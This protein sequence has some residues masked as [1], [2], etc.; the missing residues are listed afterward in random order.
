MAETIKILGQSAPS[1]TTLTTLYT[2]PSGTV[3]SISTITVCN[4]AGT[5]ATFRISVAIGGASD[6]AAQY[7]Y[8]D[9]YVDANSTFAS[10]MGIT[11]TATDVVRI[12]AST[13][14]LSFNIFGIEV[15]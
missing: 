10:T 8:Y 1:A 2:V 9:Q 4:R 6:T 5:S 11:L 7:L 12:Y 3:S 15:N 14:N 13:A